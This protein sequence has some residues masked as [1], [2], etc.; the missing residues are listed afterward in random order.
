MNEGVCFEK[1]KKIESAEKEQ[2]KKERRSDSCLD[3][4]MINI[5]NYANFYDSKFVL[6][7]QRDEFGFPEN[8]RNEMKEA[9]RKL[10]DKISDIYNEDKNVYIEREGQISH[11]LGNS[12]LVTA[13]AFAERYD[14]G[15]NISKEAR[16]TIRNEM[17]L[18]NYYTKELSKDENFLR[19][20]ITFENGYLRNFEKFFKGEIDAA[21]PNR[22]IL[23]NFFRDLEKYG[24]KEDEFLERL[25][26]IDKKT[27][28]HRFLDLQA[29]ERKGLVTVNDRE[30]RY[31]KLA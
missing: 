13:G 6:D 31:Y 20:E 7:F 17:N 12:I 2:E 25:N 29:L 21:S 19:Q 8:E 3:L 23:L 26:N 27:H 28:A 22:I 30:E 5:N 9:I 14:N 16:K 15:K 24:M 1:P 18:L 11:I 10:K 4:L